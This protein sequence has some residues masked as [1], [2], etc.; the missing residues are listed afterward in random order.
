MWSKLEKLNTI[1][2]SGM[3]VII[4]ADSDEEALLIAEN[5]IA[6]GAKA[7]EITY[8]VPNCL[9]VINT[10]S[11]KYAEKGIVIGAGTVTNAESAMAAILAGA[12][13]LVSPNLNPEMIRLA[14]EF[15]VITIS[16]AMSPTEIYNT[17]QA[18]ADIVKLF[19]ADFYGPKY[20]K[21][22]KAPLSQAPIIP[23]GGVTP[24]NVSEWFNAGC[25][26]VGVG[27]YITKAHKKDKD[28]N[29]IVTATKTFLD[30]IKNAR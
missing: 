23:T 29:K 15:Q 4:R 16:G 11:K 21:T 30:A 9:N 24:E 27:S 8:A 14:N 25:V 22:I 3:V 17:L 10:L 28:S 13:M 1:Y 20:V 18:G 19:P 5:A 12:T 2:N 26:A 6:G 7:L